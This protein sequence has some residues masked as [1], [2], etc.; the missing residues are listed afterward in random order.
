MSGAFISW[1]L[2]LLPD[3]GLKQSYVIVRI[4]ISKLFFISATIT[5][6]CWTSFAFETISRNSVRESMKFLLAIYFRVFET[7]QTLINNILVPPTHQFKKLIFV[8]EVS[9]AYY[10]IV[11]CITRTASAC[12][13]GVHLRIKYLALIIKLMSKFDMALLI[14]IA[15]FHVLLT[16][17]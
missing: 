5:K 10:I 6:K 2:S 3:M 15:S 12:R 9:F 4:K 8:S 14:Q 7:A 17:V 1:R 11:S 13:K 16:I